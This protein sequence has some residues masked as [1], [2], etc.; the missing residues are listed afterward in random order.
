MKAGDRVEWL[1]TIIFMLQKILRGY[2]FKLVTRFFT[3]I[4]SEI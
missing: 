3:G 1:A 4:D 2:F